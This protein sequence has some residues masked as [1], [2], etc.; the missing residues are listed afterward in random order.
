[1]NF[2]SKPI[3]PPS[4][5]QCVHRG[6]NYADPRFEWDLSKIDRPEADF[7]RHRSELFF[8]IGIDNRNQLV[9]DRGATIVRNDATEQSRVHSRSGQTQIGVRKRIRMR[10]GQLSI[11]LEHCPNLFEPRSTSSEY[12]GSP[13]P[14][15]LGMVSTSEHRASVNGKSLWGDVQAR[16]NFHG[17]A[18][19]NGLCGKAQLASF[20]PIHHSISELRKRQSL[21][22]CTPRISPFLAMRCSVLG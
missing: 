12:C 4:C 14:S 8:V 1:V 2:S 18:T 16:R 9:P 10:I 5:H 13:K 6:K 22:T 7:H 3:V 11:I 17:D 19:A 15:G 20:V 21:P